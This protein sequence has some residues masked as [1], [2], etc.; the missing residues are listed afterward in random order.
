LRKLCCIEGE[1]GVAENA[2]RWT[3]RPEGSNWGD[4][5]PDDQIGRLNLITPAR[6]IAAAAE[7]REGLAFCL[8][9]PLDCPASSSTR[10]GFR[11]SWRSRCAVRTGGE[12][13][14][15]PRVSRHEGS[16]QRRR[17]TLS[18]QFSTQWDALCHMGY[19]FDADG[20]GRKLSITTVSAHIS[21]CA[22]RS[23]ISMAASRRRGLM[24]RMRWGS[25]A[26]PKPACRRAE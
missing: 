10:A 25:S 18:L 15:R 24:A 12:L 9:L 26:S 7:V 16:G 5:G 3:R 4:F 19:R 20:E 8:S 23:T 21:M 11:P 14:L 17:A 22:G 2:E 13:S 6:R 1:I